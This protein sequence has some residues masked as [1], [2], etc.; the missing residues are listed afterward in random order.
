MADRAAL[1]FVAAST[2]ARSIAV[3]PTM[4]FNVGARRAW[5]RAYIATG[6]GVGV[7][8]GVGDEVEAFVFFLTFLPVFP[9]GGTA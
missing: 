6:G 5:R 8:V 7:G 3:P 2:K 1:M 9:L 4:L